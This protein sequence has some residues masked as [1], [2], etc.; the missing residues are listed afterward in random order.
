ML[1]LLGLAVLLV[2]LGSRRTKFY[3]HSGAELIRALKGKR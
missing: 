3:E 1:Y 2:A